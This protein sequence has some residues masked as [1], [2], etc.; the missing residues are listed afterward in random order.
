MTSLPGPVDRRCGH[1]GGGRHCRRRGGRRSDD[2]SYGS[3]D[4]SHDASHARMMRRRRWWRMVVVSAMMA[5]GH[6]MGRCRAVSAVM[7]AGSR[8]GVGCCRYCES[9]HEGDEKFLVVHITPDFLF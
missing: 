4:S 3:H 9:A 2:V 5:S 8:T 6:M 7:S 1:N